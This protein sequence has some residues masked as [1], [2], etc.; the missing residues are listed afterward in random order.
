MKDDFDQY[1]S[2]WEVNTST[3]LHLE[4]VQLEI[5]KLRKK[6]R[7]KIITWY[8]AVLTFCI[9]A[10][11]YV[12]YTDELAS[13]SKSTS[14]FL[15]LFA[16]IFAFRNA[17]KI[18]T[19]QKQEYLLNNTEFVTTIAQKEKLHTNRK[20]TKNYIFASALTLSVFLHFLDN[21]LTNK[22]NFWITLVILLVVNLF[23]WLILQ[24]YQQKRTTLKNTALLL[25]M[26]KITKQ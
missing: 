22:T 16:S 20:N 17:W 26:Q 19:L 10:V 2:D 24:P 15:L 11:G 7:N 12:I 25:L 3:L 5:A 13:T 18:I 21:L 6:K 9:I 8:S 23:I 4:E 1:K 14:E